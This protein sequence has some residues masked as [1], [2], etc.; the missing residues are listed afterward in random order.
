[1][2]K[3][4]LSGGPHSGKTTLLEALK[5]AYPD[6]GFL[7]EP[8]KAIM[9]EELIKQKRDKSYAP[10]LPWNDGTAFNKAVIERYISQEASL[11]AG[12][13]MSFQDRCLIDS[14][15]YCK[16]NKDN[17]LMEWVKKLIPASDYQV[18]FFCEQIGGYTDDGGLRQETEDEAYNTQEI[19]RETYK[20]YDIKFI[21]LP[22]VS[23]GKRMDL[24]LKVLN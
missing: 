15:A 16:L 13:T 7:S 20:E 8:A 18:V 10:L 19:L 12:I 21:S 5:L 2:R 3:I 11:S 1:M 24:I 4:V 6:S 14:L 22:S 9:I 17:A 23:V